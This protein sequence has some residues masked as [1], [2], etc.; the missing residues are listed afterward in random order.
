MRKLIFSSLALSALLTLVPYLL[1]ASEG[2]PHDVFL[3][4]NG[5]PI[6]SVE[7]L[8]RV[9]HETPPGRT[10][11]IGVSRDGQPLT[12]KVQLVNR[13]PEVAMGVPGK[14]FKVHV[15]PAP[16][17]VTPFVMPDL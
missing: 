15:L 12:L 3:T 1:A 16:Q 8:R 17:D 13:R 2:S 14:P 11:S 6:E 10:A 4:F 9:I 7:Q 5:A